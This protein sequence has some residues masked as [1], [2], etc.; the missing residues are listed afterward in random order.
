M[1]IAYFHQVTGNSVLVS[2]PGEYDAMPPVAALAVDFGPVSPNADRLGIAA[3]LAFGS[4]SSGTFTLPTEVSP[5]TANSIRNDSGLALVSPEPVELKPQP[6]AA[7]SRS[8]RVSVDRLPVDPTDSISIL[9]SGSWNGRLRSH[10]SIAVGTNAFLLR[11]SDQDFRPLLAAAVLLAEEVDADE[12]VVP[13]THQ[14]D[15]AELVRLQRLL[16]V[17]RLGLRQ[18]T[19]ENEEAGYA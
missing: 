16:D 4:Y 2:T 17:C 11:R 12:L 19:M 9:S 6:L 15:D 8:V 13:D 14:I 5:A 7:G 10:Y 1:Q 3:Y 18:G